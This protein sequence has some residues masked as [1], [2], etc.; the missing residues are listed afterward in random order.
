MEIFCKI[1]NVFTVT[2]DQ[3]NASLLTKK[4][5]LIKSILTDP[6]W[7]V[8]YI[9]INEDYSG[10]KKQPKQVFQPNF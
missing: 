10:G 3:F 8:V 1:I 6:F 4:Y 2:F 7:T 9:H 5:Y